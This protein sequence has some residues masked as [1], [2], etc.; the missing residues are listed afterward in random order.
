[1]SAN[2]GGGAR[3]QFQGGDGIG[4]ARSLGLAVEKRGSGEEICE[5]NVRLMIVGGADRDRV[6]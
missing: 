4:L 3:G 2:T 1:M 6:I 5:G